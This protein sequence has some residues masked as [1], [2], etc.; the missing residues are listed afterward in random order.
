[1]SEKPKDMRSDGL[2]SILSYLLALNGLSRASVLKSVRY[3]GWS[4][5][6]D[7]VGLMRKREEHDEHPAIARIGF[8]SRWPTG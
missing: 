6:C 5:V 4:F 8:A 2:L 1:M 3:L 7:H